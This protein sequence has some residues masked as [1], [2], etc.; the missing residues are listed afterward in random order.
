MQAENRPVPATL[1]VVDQCMLP[2]SASD[3][4]VGGLLDGLQICPGRAN[5][6]GTL[7]VEFNQQRTHSGNPSDLDLP[8]LFSRVSESTEKLGF[9]ESSL[10]NQVP[11]HRALLLST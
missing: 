7:E 8:P 4:E 11:E 10:L 2:A 1:L 5:L 3:N 9:W 6:A